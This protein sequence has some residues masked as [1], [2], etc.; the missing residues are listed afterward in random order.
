MSILTIIV[1]VFACANAPA[2]GP[3]PASIPQPSQTM[4]KPSQV[5]DGSDTE[6]TTPGRQILD[7][8]EKTPHMNKRYVMNDKDSV[9]YVQVFNNKS[10]LLSGFAHD[11]V[12][13]ATDWHGTVEF[14]AMHPAECEINFEIPVSALRN[15]EP[16]M[17][18]M[19]GYKKDISASDRGKI[20]GHMLGA[21]Q[22]DVDKYPI[23]SFESH[24]CA[25]VS[26]APDVWRVDGQMTL[27][28][29]TRSKQVAVTLQQRNG[30]LY[31]KGQLVFT[32]EEFGFKPYSAF[33]GSVA[34]RSEM[35]L[36]FD[37]VADPA[38]L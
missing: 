5:A 33:L 26:G 37:V 29:V 38:P 3:D 22:L 16:A 8:V 18:K 9:L 23:I 10:T 7:E 19:V 11:H 30:K 6:S 24:H 1:G 36:H 12:V 13:R 15:D 34:N 31:A 21:D 25:R 17:R 35:Q 20:L 27:R 32:H 4:T 28:G 14:D 2:L